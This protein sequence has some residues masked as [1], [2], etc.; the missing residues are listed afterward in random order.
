MSEVATMTAEE[1]LAPGRKTV[2]GYLHVTRGPRKKRY[3]SILDEVIA[4]A[5]EAA[6]I[7]IPRWPDLHAVWFGFDPDGVPGHQMVRPFLRYKASRPIDGLR[8]ECNRHRVR[9][10]C[11]VREPW[12]NGLGAYVVRAVGECLECPSIEHVGLTEGGTH[13]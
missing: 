6:G 12:S 11:T 3:E 5:V 8:S 10:I 13:G 7:T 2:E 1:W 9:L 4:D